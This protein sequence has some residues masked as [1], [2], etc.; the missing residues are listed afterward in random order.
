MTEPLKQRLRQQFSQNPPDYG[1]CPPHTSGD[2]LARLIELLRPQSDWRV[3]DVAAGGGHTT[4]TLAPL[5]A[6]VVTADLTLPRLLAARSPFESDRP[7]NTVYHQMGAQALPYRAASFNAVTC[8]LAA[9]HFPDPA[10]F[11]DECARIICVGGQVA[12]VEPIAPHNRKTARYIS[13][14]E[15]L[16]DPSHAWTY[17]LARWEGF[18]QAAGLHVTHSETL[19]YRQEFFAWAERMHCAPQTV[20]RLRAMLAQAPPAAAEWF[21]VERTATDGLSFLIHQ[22]IITGQKQE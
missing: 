22:A 17:G 14:F 6:R 10:R 4:R 20:T 2:D 5:V 11:V 13:A 18:F 7:V 15:R 21:Q 12:I 8:R 9:H 3:L 19:V 1:D 16:R